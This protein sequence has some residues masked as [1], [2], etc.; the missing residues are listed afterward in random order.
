MAIIFPVAFPSTPA[1]RSVVWRPQSVVARTESPFS[2]SQQVQ[3]H[4][5]QRWVVEMDFPPMT[6]AQ[7]EEFTAFILSLN[8]M[9]GTFLLPPFGGKTA[10]GAPAG[11][12]QLDAA[13]AA[14]TKASPATAGWNASVS[15]LLKKGDFVRSAINHLKS[16][17][18]FDAAD[19]SKTGTVSP[20]VVTPNADAGPDND[21]LAD[22]VAY[23][24]TGAGETSSLLQDTTTPKLY[25][26]QTFEVGIWAKAA[27]A[28]T[29]NI[30]MHDIPQT[31][32]PIGF[33]D[34][35]VTMAW[36]L[37][38]FQ[39]TFG[40]SPNSKIRV[41]IRNEVSQPAKTVFFWG[42]YLASPQ[43]YAL[44]KTLNDPASDV[45][46]QATLELWPAL[47][48]LNESSPFAFANM[49]G[50]FRLAQNENPWDINTAMHFG[51]SLVAMEA[52]P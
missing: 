27:S 45:D 2:L 6:R 52:V 30:H 29:L 19:W 31:D 33:Q 36:A 46:G 26:G 1:P 50:V 42:A 12:P 23:P 8:G 11:S 41:L 14:T 44:H 5:G 49:T 17:K 16:P 21:T 32:T 4:Q 22:Q 3:A 39:G 40:S 24:A 34:L 18:A 28:L 47:R 7:A 37:H 15:G 25:A 10:R 20:P 48:H 13:E 38:S 9:E 35:D 43:N 51:I